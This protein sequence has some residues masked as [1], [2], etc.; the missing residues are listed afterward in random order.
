MRQ[1][2]ESCSSVESV[3]LFARVILLNTEI[4]TILLIEQSITNGKALVPNNVS[5]LEQVL[6]DYRNKLVIE[7]RVCG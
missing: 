3:P 4:D 6:D 1:L 5:I 7:P 2:N